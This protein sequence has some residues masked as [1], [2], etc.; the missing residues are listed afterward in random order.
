[1]GVRVHHQRPKLHLCK[2]LGLIHSLRLTLAGLT[3]LGI[4]LTALSAVSPVIPN[5]V[6]NLNSL[7]TNSLVSPRKLQILHSAALRS[8]GQSNLVLC[9]SHH[10]LPPISPDMSSYRTVEDALIPWTASERTMRVE[11]LC[12]ASIGMES[13]AVLAG[14]KKIRGRLRLLGR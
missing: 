11:Y 1:M 10:L 14:R 7:T 6:R 9:L 12:G 2:I 5:E 3:G 8:E 13:S 4:R